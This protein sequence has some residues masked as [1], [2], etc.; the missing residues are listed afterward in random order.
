MRDENAELRQTVKKL[1]EQV[2]AKA[3]RKVSATSAENH[4]MRYRELKEK[5]DA[6]RDDAKKGLQDVSTLRS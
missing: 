6:A 4:A 2:R 5:L 1:S 3:A